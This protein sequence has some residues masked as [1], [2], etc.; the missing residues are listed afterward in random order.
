MKTEFHHDRWGVL[1]LWAHTC[2][3]HSN[4]TRYLSMEDANISRPLYEER[5]CYG[6]RDDAASLAA[7][8]RTSPA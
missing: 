8:S 6:C 4:S 7:K 1:V 5:P 2:G 3:H